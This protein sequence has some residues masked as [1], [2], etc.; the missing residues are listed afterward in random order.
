[1]ALPSAVFKSSGASTSVVLS[2]ISARIVLALDLCG[3]AVVRDLCKS[4]ILVLT[5]PAM[6]I[7]MNET[8]HKAC[9]KVNSST[10]S[11]S[12]VYMVITR[13]CRFVKH[14]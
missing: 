11:V 3:F 10:C 1:M 8:A 2:S 6:L 14:C 13:V 12:S 9:T 5:M 7:S 4:L